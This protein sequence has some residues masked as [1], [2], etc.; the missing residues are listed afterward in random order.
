M[1]LF[2]GVIIRHD[3]EKF[4]VTLFC[5]TEDKV[6]GTDKGMR[7][8]YGRIVQIGHL[9]DEKAAQLIRKQGI[10]ILV[11]LKGHTKRTRIDLINLG[12]APIQSAYLGF[13]GSGTGIDCDYVISDPIVTPDS[14]KPHYHEKL[15]RL[16]ESYQAND[17]THRTLPHAATRTEAGLPET[18]IVFASFNA[19]RKITPAAARLWVKI[20]DA[21]PDSVLWMMCEDEFAR[22]NFLQYVTDVG[23]E[24]DRVIFAK[25]APYEQHIAR[26]QAADIGLDTFPYNGHTTTSDKLWAGLPVVTMKGS[27]FASRVSESLLTA[28][29]MPELVAPDAAGYVK[30]CA[31]L[32]RDPHRL[33]AIREKLL[34]KRFTAPLFDTERFTRH[35]EDA[36]VRMVE[37]AKAGLEP[38]HIDIPARPARTEPF[39]A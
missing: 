17:D 3:P 32:A 18:G 11:D 10:D 7:K 35:L 33:K 13:P 26:L 23:L 12:P 6:I 27:H 38:D 20:L 39:R 31:D 15:C 16:P 5:H 21:V 2:Q 34:G 24:E 14:S 9:S 37:R 8:R 25:S 36:Y 28:L 19:I 22:S 1:R 4:D 29:E 30:L